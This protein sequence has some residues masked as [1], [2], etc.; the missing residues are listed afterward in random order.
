MPPADPVP[1]SP[2]QQQHSVG[3]LAGSIA[4]RR[5]PRGVVL[6]QLRQRLPRVELEVPRHKV[7]LSCQLGVVANCR[8][9]SPS[10]PAQQHKNKC[11]PSPSAHRRHLQQLIIRITPNSPSSR[12]VR[13]AS[14]VHPQDAALIQQPTPPFRRLCYTCAF[15][16]GDS[17][18]PRSLPRRSLTT[19]ASIPCFTSS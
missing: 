17:T 1:Q 6:T 3:N 5:S 11:N 4:P 15:P 16:R 13:R 2:V 9:L 7:A 8:R 12:E 10:Q 18:W 14:D 19:R